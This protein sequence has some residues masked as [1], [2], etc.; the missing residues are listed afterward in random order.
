MRWQHYLAYFLRGRVPCDTLAPSCQRRFRKRLP[1]P[2]RIA[3]R[4]WLVLRIGQ[5]PVGPLQSRPSLPAHL[6]GR[7]LRAAQDTTCAGPR[8]GH[9]DH[10]AGACLYFRAAPRRPVKAIGVAS[11]Q[12]TPNSGKNLGKRRLGRGASAGSSAAG[13]LSSGSPTLPQ[14]QLAQGIVN[15]G[16]AQQAR[17]QHGGEAGPQH[18]QQ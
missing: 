2:L 3:T 12:R 16:A 17:R 8:G 1:E 18:R 9:F 11:S 13:T 7:Q 15:R 4:S 10:V 14:R 5:C 6:S